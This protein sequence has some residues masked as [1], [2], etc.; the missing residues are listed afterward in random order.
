MLVVFNVVC[1]LL[2]LAFSYKFQEMVPLSSLELKIEQIVMRQLLRL[3]G[4]HAKRMPPGACSSMLSYNIH[5]T[6]YT[7]WKSVFDAVGQLT[8][9]VASFTLIGVGSNDMEV[10]SSTVW[11]TSN[12]S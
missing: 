12:K 6:V 4:S 3:H 5:N 7:L 8:V 2:K 9:I 1:M 10:D 11:A